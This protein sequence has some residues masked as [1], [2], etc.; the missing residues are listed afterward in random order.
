MTA[1]EDEHE[2]CGMSSEYLVCGKCAN[3]IVDSYINRMWCRFDDADFL[4]GKKTN[5]TRKY[6]EGGCSMFEPIVKPKKVNEQ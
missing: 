4:Q 5:I 3:I 1:G 2:G 6:W